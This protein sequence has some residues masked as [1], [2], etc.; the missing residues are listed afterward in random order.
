MIMFWE[1]SIDDVRRDL[2]KLAG[3][4]EIKAWHCRCSAPACP[5]QVLYTRV[6]SELGHSAIRFATNLS[7][8]EPVPN[9]DDMAPLRIYGV[10]NVEDFTHLL[11]DEA[12]TLEERVMWKM[13]LDEGLK[14]A[15]LNA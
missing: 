12:L 6:T 14:E 13:W 3:G 1:F 5:N 9:M 8:D 11:A 10:D 2:A 4:A 7:W 15:L